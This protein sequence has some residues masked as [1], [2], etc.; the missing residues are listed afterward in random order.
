MQAV[1][2][3]PDDPVPHDKV[4]RIEDWVKGNVQRD[5][6]TIINIVADFPA[7]TAGVRKHPDTFP[8]DLFLQLDIVLQ[9]AFLFVFL[10]DIVRRGG[11]NQLNAA[12]WYLLQQAQAVAGKKHRISCRLER[13]RKDRSICKKVRAI[14]FSHLPAKI[15]H[16]PQHGVL[17]RRLDFEVDQFHDQ[18]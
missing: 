2:E 18:A 6:G 7:E 8:D 15:P 4:E 17:R 14:H 10:A 3:T 16:G 13:V 1:L 5:D 12:V 11:D 9:L